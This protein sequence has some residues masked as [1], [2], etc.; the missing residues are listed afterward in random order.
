[1]FSPFVRQSVGPARTSYIRRHLTARDASRFEKEKRMAS[2]A[3]VGVAV[4]V[5]A[6]SGQAAN[7]T[8]TPPA[9]V[10]GVQSGDQ[11]QASP[12][13]ATK[14]PYEKLAQEML[15]DR[16]AIEKQRLQQDLLRPEVEQKER[17]VCGMRVIQADPTI[18]PKMV[19]QA[20]AGNTDY[21]IRRIEPPF[22][23]D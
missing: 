12:L 7:Q 3:F 21:K 10:P 15:A 6:I 5:V 8:A 16:L 17:T 19:L 11:E 2:P 9:P 13:F 22:C 1:M 23:N 20:P 14:T 18:D 4:F